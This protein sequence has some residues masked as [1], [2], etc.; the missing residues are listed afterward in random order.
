M[1]QIG[2]VGEHG[3]IERLELVAAQVELLDETGSEHRALIDRERLGLDR[4]DE[5][6][7]ER[8]FGQTRHVAERVVLDVANA[9]AV[10]IEELEGGEA[11]KRAPRNRLQVVVRH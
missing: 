8:E 6:G 9:I 5:V 3:L 11:T 2:Q 4:V 10:E 1:T 7:G